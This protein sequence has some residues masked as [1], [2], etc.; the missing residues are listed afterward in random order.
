MG[1]IAW[2]FP[3]QGSQTVG[4]GVDLAEHPVAKARFAEAEAI[5]GWSIL[6]KCQGDET[7]LSRTLYTQPCLYV[8][9]AILCDL[10][11]EK[12]SQVDFVAGH[13][14]GEYSAL[15]AAGVYDF[16]AGLQL[17]QKRAQLMDQ[18]SGGKMAALMKFDRT[19]LLEKIAATEG[20]TL[21]NDNS[22]QQVVISGTP[23]AVDAIMNG[24]KT[25]RAI[26]LNVSGAFHSPFMAEA[27]AQ[28]EAVLAAVEFSDAR[29]PVLSNVDPQPETQAATLKARLQKQMTGSVRWLEIMQQLSAL[30]VA[31]A[32]EIGPGKVL[33]GLIKRTCKDMATE[34]IDTLASIG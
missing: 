14:L 1:K 2:V 34:N 23:E 10:Y 31:E 25:K 33:T 29:I 16:A 17:V 11:R 18:A 19:E 12:A 3:G 22:E 24:V 27:A 4:M 26:A 15:Y 20:V 30:E 6:E 32:V 13:S 7:I 28:F 8:L 9:E 5:L 21:A